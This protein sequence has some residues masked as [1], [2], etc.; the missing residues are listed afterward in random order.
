MR[1]LARGYMRWFVT[2]GLF[3]RDVDKAE[4]GDLVVWGM[5]EHIGIYIG[6]KKAISALI[7]PWGVSVHSLNGVPL[8][9][10]YFLQVNWGNGDGPGDPDP[11]PVQVQDRSIRPR[12]Q[13]PGPATATAPAT[14]QTTP[15]TLT[16]APTRTI[17][18]SR[19]SSPPGAETASQQAS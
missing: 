13:V 18:I 12:I 11:V 9:V 8:R 4:P 7:N 2:R 10:D 6:N 17:T 16:Q 5:G 14:A 19:T 3:T 1:L 15:V